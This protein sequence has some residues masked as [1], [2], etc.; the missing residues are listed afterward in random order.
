MFERGASAVIGDHNRE[1]YE[2]VD[3]HD[4]P[5]QHA[6]WDEENHRDA[7]Q[8]LNE[9]DASLEREIGRQHLA[10]AR[11]ANEIARSVSHAAS[12]AAAAARSQARTAWAALIIALIALAVSII[13]PEK[14]TAYASSIP[15]ASWSSR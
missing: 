12:D 15:W 2:H 4:A 3:Q 7:Q 10:V 5:L 9:Q 13:T 1:E 6:V 14:I 8:W 11:E